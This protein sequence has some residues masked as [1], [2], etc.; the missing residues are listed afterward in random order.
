MNLVDIKLM[1]WESLSSRLSKST[2]TGHIIRP[3][4]MIFIY[5]FLSFIWASSSLAWNSPCSPGW[6]HTHGQS[7]CPGFPHPV[8]TQGDIIFTNYILIIKS[9][10]LYHLQYM[11]ILLPWPPR[12]ELQVCSLL[13]RM[14]ALRMKIHQEYHMWCWDCE[15]VAFIMTRTSL[16]GLPLFLCIWW[17]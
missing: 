10:H 15:K 13:A 7:F 6:P 8:S 5:S 4:H 2:K 16:L 1:T 14:D 3:S 17:C 9:K 12:Q 11:T